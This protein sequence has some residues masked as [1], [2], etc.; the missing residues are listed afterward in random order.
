MIGQHAQKARG[1]TGMAPQKFV[2][3][4]E[5]SRHGGRMNRPLD[6]CRADAEKFLVVGLGAAFVFSGV[7]GLW[8]WSSRAGRHL[9]ADQDPVTPKI[10]HVTAGRV[11][12]DLRRAR[13]PEPLPP[14]ELSTAEK[15]RRVEKISRDYDE[16]RA[17]ASADYSAAGPTFPGGLNA[18]LRQLAL[19]EFEK[20]ADLAAILS[21][22]ELEDLEL[23]ETT[24]GQL[25]QKWLGDTAATEAQRR[26][27]FRLQRAF[28]EKFALTFD[29]A[30]P[31]LLERETARHALQEQI[32]AVLGD[33][34]FAFWLQGEGGE[35]AQFVK[36]AATQGLPPETPLQLWRAKNEFTLKRLELHA[37]NTERRLPA[38]QM[39]AAQS[40]LAQQTEARILA[41][42][43]QG[44][45]V[46]ARSDVLGWLPGK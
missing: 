29:V 14:R 1:K 36:F 32:H 46:A 30:P 13:T 38:E 4:A 24:A 28:E 40:A 39:R 42:V 18:F 2:A 12:A 27:V 31:A 20:R 43:G 7:F 16:I 33:A 45:M 34:L 25:V 3:R 17:K 37:Q 41:I 5:G 9:A 15:A 26:A 11:P 6:S 35:Y 10:E 22:P 21:P 19:L 23:R 8:W 44:A